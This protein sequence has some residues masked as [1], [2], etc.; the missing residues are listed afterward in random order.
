MEKSWVIRRRLLSAKLPAL[1]RLVAICILDH[2]DS[3][4]GA[5]FPAHKTIAEI[6]LV[7]VATVKRAIAQLKNVGIITTTRT[8]SSSIYHFE[9]ELEESSESTIDELSPSSRKVSYQPEEEPH[10]ELTQLEL[11]LG[12]YTA[13]ALAKWGE[14]TGE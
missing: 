10:S 12:R 4:T 5:C 3:V 1:T 2:R 14:K 7:S 13:V 6:C 9:A 8:Y 11:S